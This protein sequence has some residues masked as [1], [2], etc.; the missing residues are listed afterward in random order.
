MH[1]GK[2]ECRYRTRHRPGYQKARSVQQR[3]E[4]SIIKPRCCLASR[5]FRGARFQQSA[6]IL[7]TNLGSGPSHNN[8]AP[9]ARLLPTRVGQ[10]TSAGRSL[11]EAEAFEER[12]EP[13][14]APQRI[15]HWVDLYVEQRPSF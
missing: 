2:C 8:D 4:W 12:G 13:C 9:R 1:D 6:P 3:S 10:H 5:V 11:E 14:V 7:S 15:E